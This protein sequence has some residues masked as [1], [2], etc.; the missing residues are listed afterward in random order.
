MP[1]LVHGKGEE[2]GRN[3]PKK[4]WAR[5]LRA[6]RLLRRG[7]EGKRGHGRRE[8]AWKGGRGGLKTENHAVRLRG[9]SFLPGAAGKLFTGRCGTLPGG[10]RRT[11]TFV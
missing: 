7:G 5:G 10:I 8:G 6:G 4:P 11:Q 3:L 1:A 2:A 9:M